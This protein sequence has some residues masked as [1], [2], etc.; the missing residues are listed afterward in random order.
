VPIDQAR[1]AR[2]ALAAYR[3]E[4]RASRWRSDLPLP[5]L[6]F[7]WGSLGWAALLAFIYFWSTLVMPD[8][9]ERGVMDT[10]AVRSGEWHRLATA[11]SLHRDLG[12]LVV[13]LVSG[14]LLFGLAMARWG[15]GLVLLAAWLAGLLGNLAGFLLYSEAHRG[16]GASGMVMGALGLL[17]T[18]WLQWVRTHHLPPRLAV[19]S[20]LGGVF[21][22]I[23]LGTNPASDVLAH[24]AGFLG[25]LLAGTAFALLPDRLFRSGGVSL[26]SGAALAALFSLTWFFAL[27]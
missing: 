6:A 14:V 9:V 5:A 26:L 17:S 2:A 1:E 8:M 16:L 25:G 20:L 4:N 3:L 15:A 24:A 13:N 27:R 11:V 22:L 10:A 21:L 7:H 18:A 19:S 23:L 12:H